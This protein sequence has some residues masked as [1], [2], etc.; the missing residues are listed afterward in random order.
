MNLFA[1]LW[2]SLKSRKVSTTLTIFSLALSTCL[3]VSMEK[4]RQGARSGFSQTVS[5]TDLIV[6]ARSSPTQ[7]LLST[8]F[9]MGVVQNNI[10]YESTS[11]SNCARTTVAER[12]VWIP[13]RFVFFSNP[14]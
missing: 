11:L 12:I 5:G 6:G 1:L 14:K 10:S 13:N 3:V 7:L 8:I 9:Q 4:V 2:K